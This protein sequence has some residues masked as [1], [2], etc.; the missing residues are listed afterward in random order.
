LIT[1][2]LR[3]AVRRVG[4]P[5]E[6]SATGFV[7]CPSGRRRCIN[8]EWLCDGYDDCGDSSDEDQDT[9]LENGQPYFHRYPQDASQMVGCVAQ[10]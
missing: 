7:P 6:C 9:C 8:E 1:N 4:D 10:R 5:P 2:Y 3:V